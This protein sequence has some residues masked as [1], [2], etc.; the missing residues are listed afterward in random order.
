[1]KCIHCD[2]KTDYPTRQGNRLRCR[3]C[4][5]K[6]AFEPRTDSLKMTDPLFQRKIQNVSGD[7][8]VFFTKK[9]LWYEL[10]RHLHARSWGRRSR[11]TLR[12]Q[13]NHYLS[14][15]QLDIR[16]PFEVFCDDYLARWENVHR[17]IENLVRPPEQYPSQRQQEAEP[18]LT[19]YSFD[20]ALITD[21]SEIAAMLVANNFHFE[22]NCA[23]LSLDG[24][25]QDIADTVLTM[26]KRNPQL[27]VFAL[28]DASAEGCKLPLVL[29]EEGW[30]PDPSISMIDL[31]LR[32]QHAKAMRLFT[33]TGRRQ[34]L[35]ADV[36]GRLTDE[37]ITWLE[38]GNTTEVEALRP[39]RLMRA[40][41][42]GF[43]HA[44][45]IDTDVARED[46]GRHTEVDGGYI[47]IYDSGVDVYAA[48]SFG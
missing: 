19:A 43:A 31:G 46:R 5:H 17:K 4:G 15:R 1:M 32:P 37:E 38:R 29:R 44:T 28:H 8:T 25:R 39:E 12:G 14:L 3:K 20:R 10:N 41:Y 22:N 16:L 9:Q 11:R 42:Q 45:Q 18:D 33:L 34:A 35:S 2:S 6:F 36:R 47:W 30:F 21:R 13:L 7:G 27:K 40:S 48:D 23:I 24:Y 26:L